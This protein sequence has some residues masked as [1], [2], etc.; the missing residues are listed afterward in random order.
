LPL[1]TSTTWTSLPDGTKA[2]SA[3]KDLTL[4]LWSVPK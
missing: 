1:A 4:R 2:L 3:G